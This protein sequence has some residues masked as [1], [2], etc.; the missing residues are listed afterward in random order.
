MMYSY[1]SHSHLIHGVIFPLSWNMCEA[2]G[3]GTT[4]EITRVGQC[5]TRLGG[6]ADRGER[7]SDTRRKG[8]KFEFPRESRLLQVDKSDR[9]TRDALEQRSRKPSVVVNQ[10]ALV[11]TLLLAC[12][13]LA[14]ESLLANWFTMLQP[15]EKKR[16]ILAISLDFG[17]VGEKSWGK[18]YRISSRAR[19]ER[20]KSGNEAANWLPS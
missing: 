2:G 8:G 20:K 9:I 6:T 19:R 13:A 1:Q 3:D 18:S 12:Y 16:V 10:P 11:L 14:T 17:E 4:T 7:S 5:G 15:G